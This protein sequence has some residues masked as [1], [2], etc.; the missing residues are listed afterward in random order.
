[1][2]LTEK[3]M[4]PL[5]LHLMEVLS[6]VFLL[7]VVTSAVQ[8]NEPRQKAGPEF[9]GLEFVGKQVVSELLALPQFASDKNLLV[10]IG[11]PRPYQGDRSKTLMF[12]AIDLLSQVRT[13]EG[14]H[15]H[16]KNSSSK[17]EKYKE[18]LE[19]AF[20]GVS[21][22]LVET[23]RL[24]SQVTTLL[25]PRDQWKDF[26]TLTQME[27]QCDFLK[28]RF[29]LEL[30]RLA[31]EEITQTFIVS[32]HPLW[33]RDGVRKLSE[34][35]VTEE[36]PMQPLQNMNTGE[37]DLFSPDIQKL[38]AR[39]KKAS[40]EV[41]PLLKKLKARVLGLREHYLKLANA[42]YKNDSY[43]RTLDEVI[44]NSKDSNLQAQAAAVKEIARFGLGL[45]EG[46]L[47]SIDSLAEQAE[48]VFAVTDQYASYVSQKITGC[49][50]AAQ[51]IQEGQEKEIRSDVPAEPTPPKTGSAQPASP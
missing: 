41:A 17:S 34:K 35:I 1:M 18:N 28:S 8:A 4:V 45:D 9:V 25:V 10:M 46:E 14:E 30:R 22:D 23:T 32:K 36:R 16:S 33:D 31:G 27:S 26:Q 49:Q 3:R 19:K 39:V 44:E 2:K 50:V 13:L 12:R 37:I 20:E 48:A 47:S 5:F 6:I 21:R 51:S 15:L 24:L 38:R 11:L 42:I 7:V 29:D 43:Y 40:E